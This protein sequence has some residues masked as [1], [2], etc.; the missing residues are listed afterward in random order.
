MELQ[1]EAT[2]AA[3]FPL[4]LTND[5]DDVDR[6]IGDLDDTDWHDLVDRD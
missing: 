3:R 2:E 6:S 4:T 5:D 1:A